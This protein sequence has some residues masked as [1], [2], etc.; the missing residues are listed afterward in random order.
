M[1]PLH[2]QDASGGIGGLTAH[3]DDA[4][5]EERQPIFPVTVV[6]RTQQSLMVLL[7]TPPAGVRDVRPRFA[8]DPSLREPE[9]DQLTPDPAIIVEERGMVP[10]CASARPISMSSGRSPT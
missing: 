3:L 9:R 6:A 5:E 7:S 2:R 8:Q 4:S 1:G 10:N